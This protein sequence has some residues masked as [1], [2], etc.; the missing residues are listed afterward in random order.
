M[1][2]IWWKLLE[3][4]LK[5]SDALTEKVAS[6]LAHCVLDLYERRIGSMNAET[7]MGSDHRHIVNH[8]IRITSAKSMPLTARISHFQLIAALAVLDRTPSFMRAVFSRKVLQRSIIILEETLRERPDRADVH[9]VAI[10]AW[11][12][13]CR[14]AI[15][16]GEWRFTTD[17][18][19]SG[20]F[21]YMFKWS[22]DAPAVQLSMH[23]LFSV[24][25]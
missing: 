18:V 8:Y 15:I 3:K 13:L 9:D 11:N 6:I 7:L 1:S 14:V 25:K 19:A 4:E 10:A 24:S 20:L 21:S 5:D 16:E 2:K 12:E 23:C 17:A 22:V